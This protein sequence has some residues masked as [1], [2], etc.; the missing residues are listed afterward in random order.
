MSFFNIKAHKLSRPIQSIGSLCEITN[1]LGDVKQRCEN[2][3]EDFEPLERAFKTLGS[4]DKKR[5]EPKHEEMLKN[6][7]G[8][9][10]EVKD[11]HKK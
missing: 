7:K 4:F 6:L 11:C 10:R 2:I 8:Q 1:L 9:D 3:D 5:V